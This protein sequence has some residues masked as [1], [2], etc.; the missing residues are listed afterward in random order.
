MII[1]IISYIFLFGILYML[2]EKERRLKRIE[3]LEKLL[4]K[5]QRR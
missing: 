2:I 4:V 3:R 5:K 1:T